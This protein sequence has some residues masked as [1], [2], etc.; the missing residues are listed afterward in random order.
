[1][2][3][4]SFCAFIFFSFSLM[5]AQFNKAIEDNSFF[6]EEAY[7]QEEG[8]VQHI[9]TGTGNS[10]A[11]FSEATFTQEWP[12]GGQIHQLSF[13]LP[14]L[15]TTSDPSKNGVGDLLLNY[16]YQAVNENGLAVAPR[17][18]LI[19]PTGDNTNGLGN[20]VVGLQV[21][22]PVSKRWSNEVVTHGNAG[23]TYLPNVNIGTATETQTSYFVGASGIYLA[24]AH[25]NIV[26]E[27]LYSSDSGT[28]EVILNPGVR[29]A[30]DMGDLQIVPGFAFPI[31]YTPGGQENGMFLYLSFEHPF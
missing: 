19:I 31:F 18:S 29:F 1:M 27:A 12:V 16:R 20:G 15:T 26:L 2:K 28:T 7:N 21:N 11:T 17:F 30:I 10:R 25:F 24:N 8:I 22:V 3:Q 6:I 23:F 13:T 14:Y 9:F 4:L 5:H